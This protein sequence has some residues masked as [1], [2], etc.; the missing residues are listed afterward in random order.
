MRFI[1]EAKFW[2]LH[3]THTGARLGIECGTLLPATTG[4]GAVGFPFGHL[5]FAPSIPCTLTRHGAVG[6]PVWLPAL[7]AQH[8]MEDIILR[9]NGLGKQPFEEW[10]MAP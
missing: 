5:R 3:A 9:A 7:C 1:Q 8:S 10:A 4:H 2:A 6:L